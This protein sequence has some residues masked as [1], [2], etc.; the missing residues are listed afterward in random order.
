MKTQTKHYS[1]AIMLVVLTA[2]VLQVSNAV[3]QC[4]ALQSHVCRPETGQPYDYSI[5]QT[6]I[7]WTVIGVIPTS[8]DDKDVLM[9]PSC[10][11]GTPLATSTGVNG[12]DFVVG[13]FNHNS[14]GTYYP[15]ASYGDA[16]SHYDVYWRNGGMIF[17]V[18]HTTVGSIGGSGAG[19]NMIH[20]YDIKLEAGWEYK[21]ELD[22][23]LGAWSNASLFHNP[24]ASAYW[25]GRYSSEL[26]TAAPDPPVFYLAPETDWYGLVVFPNWN[27]SSSGSYLI[28]VEKLGDCIEMEPNVCMT[29]QLYSIAQGPAN[30]YLFIQNQP[31]W[32]AVAVLPDTLDDKVLQFYSE[33]DEGG[34]YLAGS[35]SGGLGDTEFIIADFNHT[36]YGGYHPSV[37]SGDYSAD[38]SISWDSGT[39]IFPVPGELIGLM[40][41]TSGD[42]K[43]IQVWDVY[44]EAGVQYE[45]YFYE[46][47]EKDPRIALFRNPAANDYIVGRSSSEFE[48]AGSSYHTYTAPQTDWYGL[49]VFANERKPHQ[50]LWQ[51]N[52]EP[53]ND[54][55]PLTSGECMMFESWPRDFEFTQTNVFWSAIAA[56]PDE[57]DSKGLHVFTQCDAKGT[58]LAYSPAT[59]TS[60]IVGDFN[61]TPT[62]TYYPTVTNNSV[63]APWVIQSDTDG[64]IL[65]LDTIVSGVVGRSW[66]DCEL[67]K[68]WD[69]YLESGK[70]YQVGF[71]RSGEA[72]VRLALFRNPGSGAYWAPRYSSEFELM[73]SGN[74]TYAAPASDWYGIVVFANKHEEDGTYTIAISEEGVTA[75]DPLK[76]DPEAFALYQNA[77]NPF[78]PTTVI[79]YDV[80]AGGGHVT[81]AVYDVKG[82][83]VKLI[84]EGVLDAGL[85][86]FSWDGTDSAG[87]PAASGVYFCRLF[88]GGRVAASEKM[89]LIR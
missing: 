37:S 4:T 53:L 85:R 35:A 50:S 55:V 26:E 51:V 3:A 30:D 47:G 46:W 56:C 72:D 79:R 33:C 60:F 43:D 15:R 71:T 5:N 27:M 84:T 1:I 17:P 88:V 2:A 8:P 86:E 24:S 41:G 16:S 22:H 75:I 58:N 28:D 76:T 32:S 65:N 9:F 29:K 38:F 61:H 18:S 63:E 44:L 69:V 20:I 70:T 52:I 13:D 10:G 77:P 59:G 78:N 39:D 23:G 45:F 80:P 64:S 62:G 36:P 87:R 68:I 21:I 48:L 66:P 81:L 57:G 34:A 74:H 7:Y 6:L 42:C 40:D 89:V 67:I 12:T 19:C 25:A 14:L 49:V 54:C 82:R 83:F 73:G 31:Y 11:S